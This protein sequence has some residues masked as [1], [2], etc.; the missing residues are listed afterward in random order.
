VTSAP[1]AGV[2]SAEARPSSVRLL[3]FN[4]RTR[5]GSTRDF[6]NDPG[7]I[8]LSFLSRRVALSIFAVATLAWG[9]AIAGLSEGIE[10][11]VKGDY[12]AAV[13]ELRPLAERG[14]AEAQYRLG[15]MYEFGKGV[16]LD[17]VQA[18]V[19]LRKSAAQGNASAQ[20]E[21]GVMYAMGEGVKQDDKLAVEW[22]QKAAAQ[23]NPT[24][25]YNLALMYA[26]GKGV[27]NDNARAIA[28]FRQAA[29]QGYAGAQFKLG[30]AY[31]NGE[32]VAR[33]EV[34]AFANYAIAARDGNKD[35][36]AYRDAIGKKLGPSQL[37]Q[38][39]GLAA[40]WQVGRPTPGSTGTSRVQAVTTV[41]TSVPRPNRCSASGQ[42]EGERFTATHCAV[43]L[44]GDQRS[45]AI[46]FNQEPI[47]PLEVES[48][49][50]SSYADGAKDGKQRT[51]VVIMFCPGGGAM[52]ASAAAV[53]SIDLNTNHAQSPLAGIQWVV[54]SPKD[55][56]VEKMSGE[57]RPGA[58]LTG[59]IVGARAKTTWNLDFDVTLPEKDAA[60]GMGC[61]K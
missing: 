38:A 9:S 45:V 39:Q 21:L 59:R 52:T 41:A 1:H 10:A 23:G 28:L 51:L 47:S 50:M 53:R 3:R 13:R 43:S 18:L 61:G 19:W 24:A 16:A 31:E 14:D 6:V 4:S 27:P 46:W 33:D 37:R 25:Q 58:L 42:M 8:H 29:D 30:V 49:Q 5:L 40:D 36:A 11:I 48:F 55:Y 20:L 17:M 26:K 32:G 54:E 35:Y 34:L 44:F 12:A 2:A 7:E 60:A 15:R 22:F 56:K 57:V